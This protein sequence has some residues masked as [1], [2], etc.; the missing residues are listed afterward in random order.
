[1]RADWL[2]P[3]TAG[4]RVCRRLV[5]LLVFLVGGVQPCRANY[6]IL[7]FGE[8]GSISSDQG[9]LYVAHQTYLGVPFVAKCE[10]LLYRPL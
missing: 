5:L 2:D 9:G 10:L 1:M 3:L 7:T 6:A 8:Y 4:V